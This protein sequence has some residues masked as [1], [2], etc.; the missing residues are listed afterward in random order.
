MAWYRDIQILTSRL[1]IVSGPDGGAAGNADLSTTTE[2]L[3]STSVVRQGS[4]G[5]SGH[6]RNGSGSDS[7]LHIEDEG[8]N[9]NRYL[10]QVDL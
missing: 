3:M 9:S 10:K 8:R 7:S 2:Q 1:A 4:L 6:S 5:A